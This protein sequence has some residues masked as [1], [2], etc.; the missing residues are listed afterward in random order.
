M[1]VPKGCQKNTRGFRN[2][3]ILEDTA[4]IKKAW[5]NLIFRV[6][7]NLKRKSNRR[8]KSYLSKKHVERYFPNSRER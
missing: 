1:T 5:K 3:I 7:N 2:I 8:I 4:G 6:M